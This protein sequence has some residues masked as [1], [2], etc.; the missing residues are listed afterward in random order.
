MTHSPRTPPVTKAEI[1]RIAKDYACRDCKMRRSCD[2]ANNHTEC[3]EAGE[4][5][6]KLKE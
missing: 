4:F 1:Y 2:A 6:R 5:Y 3:E